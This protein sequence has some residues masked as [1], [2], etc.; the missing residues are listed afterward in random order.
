MDACPGTVEHLIALCPGCGELPPG[1][2]KD[3]VDC[4]ECGFTL[5]AGASL[6]SCGASQPDLM[7]LEPSKALGSARQG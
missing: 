2:F 5:P 6:C 7:V 4:T 1:G 3:S